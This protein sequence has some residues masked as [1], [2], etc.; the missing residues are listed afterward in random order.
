MERGLR[1]KAS[2]IDDTIIEEKFC[3]WQEDPPI[4]HPMYNNKICLLKENEYK[5]A[6]E[7]GIEYKQNI[8]CDYKTAEQA[9]KCEQYCLIKDI[10]WD[11]S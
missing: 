2:I 1:R 6:K 4:I 10:K 3:Y 8:L 5:L 7:L 11:K 9:L